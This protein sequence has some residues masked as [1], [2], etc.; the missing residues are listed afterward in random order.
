MS[1]EIS[2]KLLRNFLHK[3]YEKFINLNISTYTKILTRDLDNV[4]GGIFQSIISITGD[5]IYIIALIF[6]SLKLIEIDFYYSHLILVIALIVMLIFIWKLSIKFGTLRNLFETKIFVHINE[7]LSAI[8][9]IKVFNKIDH[10]S[11]EF[12]YKAK[13][14]YQIRTISGVINLIP[15]TVFE[16]SAFLFLVISYSNFE[17]NAVSFISSI[18]ILAFIFMRILPPVNKIN[19]NLNSCLNYHE[20]LN[21]IKKNLSKDFVTS[22]IKNKKLLSI[23]LSKIN[24]Y[25]IKNKKKINIINN[26]S[27]NFKRGKIYGLFGKS[28]KGKT[29]LLNILSGLINPKSGNIYINNKKIK[30]QDIYKDYKVSL[31]NQEPYL[32]EGSILDN[33][34]F[35]FRN[36]GQNNILDNKRIQKLLIKFNLKKYSNKKFLIDNNMSL[37]KK[38][39]GGEK[40]RLSIIRC[41]YNDPQLMILDEPTAALDK[42]NEGILIKFLKKYKKNKIIILT[43]H[44]E[45]LKKYL[46]KVVKI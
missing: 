2:K 4:V 8:K 26:F 17:G 12:F 25:Y 35:N 38:L 41:I 45:Y 6:F 5:L 32:I 36:T 43:T 16:I 30:S 10:F 31:L 19:L 23:R 40:Q 42:K 1:A 34:I 46:D 24:Y 9:E 20:S 22:K 18:S 14:F 11:K 7:T 21:L 37:N 3:N 15:K 33:I 13:K 27:I 44:R 29:T 28:G 39:S